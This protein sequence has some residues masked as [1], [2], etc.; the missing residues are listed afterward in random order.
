[1]VT[2]QRER[3][4]E[5]IHWLGDL[6]APK[7]DDQKDQAAVLEEGEE[8]E[9]TTDAGLGRYFDEQLINVF[10]PYHKMANMAR[11]WFKDEADRQI[12]RD[13]EEEKYL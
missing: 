13:A 4:L 12:L 3:C 11:Q 10:A 7:E 6:E 1:M 2:K 9:A 5:V 8:K